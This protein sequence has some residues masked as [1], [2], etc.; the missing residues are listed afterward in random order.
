MK[1]FALLLSICLLLIGGP[2][3]AFMVGQPKPDEL[4]QV[5]NALFYEQGDNARMG[6]DIELL[7]SDFYMSDGSDIFLGKGGDTLRIDLTYS[8]SEPKTKNL[9]GYTDGDAHDIV[10]GRKASKNNRIVLH[11]KTIEDIAEPIMFTD[12][13]KKKV[14]K[15]KKVKYKSLNRWYA[16][17]AL[18]KK[19]QKDHF[20]AFHIDGQDMLDAY[21]L[22]VGTIYTVGED[23]V[24]MIAFEDKNLG[25]GDYND[26]V[27]II[28]RPKE[29]NPV[30][31]PIPGAAALLLSGL[32]AVTGFRVRR[33]MHSE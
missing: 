18:N 27:A 2:V 30:P 24:W 7:N 21:N 23:D 4:H 10:I 25:D 14:K 32:V 19:G 31:T 12:T 28:S 22:L 13:V 8:H 20:Y 15:N 3:Q 6:S 16:D 29:F 33:S 5:F 17:A 26:L 1:V 9:L 11:N